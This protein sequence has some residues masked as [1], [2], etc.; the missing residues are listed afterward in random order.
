MKEIIELLLQQETLVNYKLK[1][2]SY[3]ILIEE[4]FV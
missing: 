2:I 3:L 1:N 4:E